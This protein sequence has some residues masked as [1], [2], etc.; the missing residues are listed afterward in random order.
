M[1][2]CH[3]YCLSYTTTEICIVLQFQQVQNYFKP[4]SELKADTVCYVNLSF[5]DSSNLLNR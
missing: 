1:N 3:A 2:S 4:R 5:I